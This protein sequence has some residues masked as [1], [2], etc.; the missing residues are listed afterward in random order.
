MII[1]PH[2][3]PPFTSEQPALIVVAGRPGAGKGTL[4]A[5]IAQD[6]DV[7][8]FSLGDA[9][10]REIDHCT[11][12]GLRAH[13]F[14]EGGRLVPDHLV[15]ELIRARLA[16][17]SA[18]VVLLDGFPRT[19]GQAKTLERMRPGA[20][21]LAIFLTVH[22]ATLLE[23]LE[24]RGRADDDDAALC[25]RLASFK[26]DTWPMLA[27]YGGRGCLASVDGN[28]LQADVTIAAQ[29]LL[30]SRVAAV[31]VPASRSAHTVGSAATPHAD[32][33][34]TP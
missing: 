27:W 13:A 34:P 11:P 9:F 20:V 29:A 25:E 7:A 24:S 23:R 18:P 33:T 8:H 1:N 21:R 22:L 31:Q 6:R 5:Q 2:Y 12:L 26:R 10:R 17:Q 15:F 4:C 3:A 28:Q 32:R 16:H 19:L 14:L 30:A